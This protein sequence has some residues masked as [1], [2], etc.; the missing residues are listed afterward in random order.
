MS[1]NR[2]PTVQDV[3]YL[4]AF[5][6]IMLVVMFVLDSCGDFIKSKNLRARLDAI[7]ARCK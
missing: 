1:K 4:V 5:L 2:E 7:E 3:F 6:A